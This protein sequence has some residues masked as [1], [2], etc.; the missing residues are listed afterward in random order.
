MGV[1]DYLQ[2][3][4]ALISVVAF[5]LG[6]ILV[7]AVA[8]KYIFTGLSTKIEVWFNAYLESYREHTEAEVRIE[9]RL[10]ELVG[11]IE[12]IL[13]HNWD[14]KRF[15]DGRFDDV[16][17]KLDVMSGKLDIVVR[18]TPKRARDRVEEEV[19]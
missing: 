13:A 9:E 10:R 6:L 4:P 16:T 19:L 7:L 5:P 17:D 3:N 18:A 12:E 8:Q 2:Q 11:K 14:T 15:F 1:L